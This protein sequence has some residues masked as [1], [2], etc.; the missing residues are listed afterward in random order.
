MTDITDQD[1]RV[2]HEWAASIGPEMDCL[3]AN[4]RAVARVILA[5]VDAPAPTLAEELRSWAEDASYDED[6]DNL[7][8]AADRAEQM[9]HG[10]AEARAEVEKERDFGVALAHERDDARAKVERLKRDLAEAYKTRDARDDE[11]DSLRADVERLTALNER[12]RKT[13]NYREFR[14]KFLTVQ[15]GAESNAESLGPADVKPGEAWIVECRGERR[16]AVKDHDDAVPWC[17][18]NADGWFLAEDNEEVTLIYRLVPAPRVITNADELDR[19]CPNSVILSS[20]NDAWQ[21]S[22]RTILWSSPWWDASHGGPAMWPS[23][24][25]CDEYHPVTVLWEQGA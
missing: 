19:L 16:T 25:I 14:D 4:T 13:D 9:E 11:V 7:L 1:R 20:D 3:S 5:T 2:A 6:R 24:R 17:T 10:I 15:K 18:F 8:H 12:L 23:E 21:K 22:T